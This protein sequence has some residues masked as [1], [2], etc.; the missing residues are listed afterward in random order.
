MIINKMAEIKKRIFD[1]NKLFTFVIDERAFLRLTGIL[2]D[3]N[4]IEQKAVVLKALRS[5]ATILKVAG[6]HEFKKSHKSKTGN[7]YRSFTTSLKRRKMGHKCASYA[8]FKKNANK[9]KDNG[10]IASGNHAHLIDRGTDKRWRYKTKK[11]TTGSISRNNPNNGSL[12][13]TRTAVYNGPKLM[14]RVTDTVINIL[15]KNGFR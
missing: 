7:L 6:R 10:G 15:S 5:A 1:P 8:G 14:E 13:W 2:E 9:N 4:D 3:L 12:F 11:G